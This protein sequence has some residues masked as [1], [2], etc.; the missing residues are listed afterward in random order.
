[1]PHSFIATTD[2]HIKKGERQDNGTNVLLG[3]LYTTTPFVV[4]PFRHH[5]TI[6]LSLSQSDTTLELALVTTNE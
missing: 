2:R 4:D 6:K 3:L 5:F 1:M